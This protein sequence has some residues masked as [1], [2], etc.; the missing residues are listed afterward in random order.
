MLQS[1]DVTVKF[2]MWKPVVLLQSLEV[3]GICND[4]TDDVVTIF[5]NNFNIF[6]D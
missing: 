4:V 2:V 3:A 1:L 6:N 5:R